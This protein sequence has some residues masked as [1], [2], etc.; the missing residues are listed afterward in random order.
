MALSREA[1]IFIHNMVTSPNVSVPA[2]AVDAVIELRQW[3]AV[4]LKKLDQADSP[5]PGAQ[6]A[7]R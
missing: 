1:I 7:P 3:T 5:P 4:E 6:G 2:P